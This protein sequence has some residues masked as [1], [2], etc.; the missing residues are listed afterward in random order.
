[1]AKF[2]GAKWAQILTLMAAIAASLISGVT[3]A[4]DYAKSYADGLKS[5]LVAGDVKF[6]SQNFNSGSQTNV[7]AALEE[8][9][10]AQGANDVT[11]TRLQ[12]PNSGKLATYRF[13]KGSGAGATT[14]D[15]DLAYDYV[16]N[17]IGIVNTDGEGNSGYFL[18][19]NVAATGQ[20][21]SY[22]YLDVSGLVEYLTLGDQTGKAVKLAIVNHQ[23]TADI[24]DKA[25]LKK[26]LA[27]SVQDSLDDADSALQED[28]FEWASD[29]E[30]TTSWTSAMTTAAANAAAAANQG[31]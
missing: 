10:A 3:E 9:F 4:K 16:N 21:A 2:K 18:K 28:D 26:H 24:E 15:I 27:Q 20:T 11:F 22:E 29:N 30:V 25:I 14:M 23:I 17:I 5:A 8:L 7:G 1:M 6:T 12:T 13:T 31:E 19:V